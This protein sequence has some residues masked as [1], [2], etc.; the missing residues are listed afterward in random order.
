MDGRKLLGIIVTVLVLAGVVWLK[1]RNRGDDSQ[2]IRGEMMAVIESMPEFEKNSELLT[3]WTD[4]A[5]ETAFAAAYTMA[6]RRTRAKFDDERYVKAF[7][8]SMIS[9]ARIQQKKTLTR[10]ALSTRGAQKQILIS[11]GSPAPSSAC[12]S[13]YS[14]PETCPAQLDTAPQPGVQAPTCDIETC[15]HLVE[16]VPA[17]GRGKAAQFIPIRFIFFNKLTKDDRLLLAYDAFVLRQALGRDI[18]ESLRRQRAGGRSMMGFRSESSPKPR[19][20]ICW[21]EK[22]SNLRIRGGGKWGLLWPTRFGRRVV[23]GKQIMQE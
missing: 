6:G 9:Q 22:S 1:L 8:E 21:R 23:V 14:L 12:G 11:N 18:A 16:R 2:Q 5:H 13:A 15:L 10:A 17:E 4:R 19:G 3:E 20:N 7:F